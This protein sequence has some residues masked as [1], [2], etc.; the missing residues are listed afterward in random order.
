MYSSYGFYESSDETLKNI[1]KPIETDL[2]ELS[3]LRKVYFEWKDKNNGCTGPQ[4]GIIAQDIKN[5][6]PEIVDGEEG[7]YTV[8]YEKLGV[9]ALDAIDKIYQENKALKARC[10]ALEDRVTKLEN[11]IIK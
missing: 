2:E 5:V 7:S 1:L 10:E 3:K 6:Y 11:I 4:I 8:Q 9:I